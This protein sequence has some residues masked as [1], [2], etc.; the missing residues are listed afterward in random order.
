MIR[1]VNVEAIDVKTSIGRLEGEFLSNRTVELVLKPESGHEREVI[2]TVNNA[3]DLAALVSRLGVPEDEAERTAVAYWERA[4]APVWQEWSE[5]E[6]KRDV[7]AGRWRQ[8]RQAISRVA[9]R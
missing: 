4:I 2:A 9:R 3:D 7:R 5:R 8:I 1:V 6:R